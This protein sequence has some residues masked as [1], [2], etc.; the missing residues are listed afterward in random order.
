MQQNTVIQIPIPKKQKLD[1][2]IVCPV[3]LSGSETWRLTKK[4]QIELIVF[5]NIILRI[6]MGQH[7]NRGSGEENT[8]ETSRALYIST[9]IICEIK[10]RRIRWA[11]I[12]LR[13]EEEYRL[14]K[15]LKS[16][17]EGRQP[18]GRLKQIWWAQMKVDIE[19]GLERL[20]KTQRTG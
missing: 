6:Y 12:I 2:I 16:N 8:I 1:K 9:D 4:D 7:V 19:K 15:V 10:C 17:S 11:G 13:R 5:N 3:L 20:K 18:T 14:K